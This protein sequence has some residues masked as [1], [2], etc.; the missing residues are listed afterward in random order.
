[1]PSEAAM[2]YSKESKHLKYNLARL[3]KE[4]KL[5][6][7]NKFAEQLKT[8]FLDVDP[9]EELFDEEITESIQNESG[10]QTNSWG[11]IRKNINFI[12][13]K[14]SLEV[15]NK[16]ITQG[17]GVGDGDLSQDS[18]DGGSKTK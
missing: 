10:A 14:P 18:Q 15:S 8:A 3:V 4:V 11:H 2:L 6:E 1:M 9:T 12:S 16:L 13:S 17:D 5:I 7:K